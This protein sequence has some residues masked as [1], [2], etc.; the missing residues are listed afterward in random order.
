MTT[1]IKFTVS[2]AH[3]SPKYALNNAVVTVDYRDYRKYGGQEEYSVTLPNFGCGK[4]QA[5]PEAAIRSLLN[6]NGCTY[7]RFDRMA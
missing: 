5:T 1:Q 2:T 6:D 3:V 7:I 4:S